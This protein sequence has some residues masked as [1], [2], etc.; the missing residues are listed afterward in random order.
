MWNTLV[1]CDND[2]FTGSDG[3]AL[4][5]NFT[6]LAEGQAGAPAIDVNS[7]I[8]TGVASIS[9]LDIRSLAIIEGL[10]VDSGGINSNTDGTNEFLKTKIIEIGDWDMDLDQSV[11]V[12]HGLTLSKIRNVSVLIRNDTGLA[13]YSLHRIEASG[14]AIDGGINQIE[15]TN[16]VLFREAALFF[17][18]VNFDSTSFNRGWITIIY[19]V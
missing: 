13:S 14:G 12:A 11:S 4:Q 8:V 7:F 19:A 16:V 15:T 5:G 18:S 10:Q 9:Q 2:I 6:A 3:N 1:F 17:D